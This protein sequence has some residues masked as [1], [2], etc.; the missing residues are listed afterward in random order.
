MFRSCVRLFSILSIGVIV[1]S[2][3]SNLLNGSS[4]SQ[5]SQHLN[6]YVSCVGEKSIQPQTIRCPHECTEFNIDDGGYLDNEMNKSQE[7]AAT[8]HRRG[9]MSRMVKYIIVT[10]IVVPL[11]CKFGAAL[12]GFVH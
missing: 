2:S 5:D 11:F 6:R 12:G 3:V 8:A 9:E 4:C 1:S 7:L 10:S